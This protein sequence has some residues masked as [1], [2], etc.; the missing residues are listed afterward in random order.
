MDPISTLKDEY[1]KTHNIHILNK[2]PEC[3]VLNDPNHDANH[4]TEQKSNKIII[5]KELLVDCL[6]HSKIY[7]KKYKKIKRL[8]DVFD[9]CNSLMSSS[10]IALIVVGFTI[11]PCLIISACLSGIN[12]VGS[13]VQDKL[14]LKFKHNQHHLTMV[15]YIALAREITTVLSKNNLSSSDYQ[16]YIEEVSDKL[17]LINDSQI[18]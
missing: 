1:E 10:A 3:V 11:P 13:R 4:K 14:K 12:L 17:N 9:V 18:F 16:N 2:G 8:D 6:S 15:Q 5:L 7:R